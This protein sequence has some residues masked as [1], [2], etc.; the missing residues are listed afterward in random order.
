MIPAYLPDSNVPQSFSKLTAAAAFSVMAVR[1]S[2]GV[3]FKLDDAKWAITVGSLM[4][5]EPGLKSLANATATPSSMSFLAGA[6]DFPK[7]KLVPGSNVAM[8]WLV[9]NFEIESSCIQIK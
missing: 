3:I 1:I 7:K 6:N 5:H 4:V 9:D 8:V 2:S